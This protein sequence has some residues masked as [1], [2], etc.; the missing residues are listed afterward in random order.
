VDA[1]R[2]SNWDSG[3][4]ASSLHETGTSTAKRVTHAYVIS[5]LRHQPAQRSLNQSSGRNSLCKTDHF[6]THQLVRAYQM[7]AQRR[8]EKLSLVAPY[9][10]RLSGI[11]VDAEGVQIRVFLVPWGKGS[12]FV[13]FQVHLHKEQSD[14]S[15]GSYRFVLIHEINCSVVLAPTLELHH[16]VGQL[17]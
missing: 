16:G 15:R 10:S 2:L 5:L 8:Q 17:M 9:S 6:P 11:W 3:F 12:T 7:T 1:S 4:S 13:D 14:L